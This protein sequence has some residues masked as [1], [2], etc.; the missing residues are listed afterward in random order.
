MNPAGFKQ[1]AED[2]R[3]TYYQKM[4]ES[5]VTRLIIQL[6]I[7]AIISMMI[8]NIYN[9]VDTAFVG[10]LG[11]SASAAV[12]IVFGFMAILQAV[13]FLFG[14]GSGSILGRKLGQK[15]IGD[16][17]VVASTGFFS[18][19]LI[20]IL[21]EV[22]GLFW[23]ETLVIQLGSTATIAPYTR[24]YMIYILLSSPFM[25]ASCAMNT[26]LRYEGKALFAMA[27]MLSGAVLNIFG[28][29]FFMF[30]LHMGIAG[31]GLSTALSQFVGFCIL[32]SPFLTRKTQCRLSFRLISSK[33]IVYMDIITTGLPSMTRQALTSISTILLNMEAG[34][35]GDAAVAAMSIVSRIMF[36]VFA[37]ALGIGQGF[38]PVCGFNYGAGKYRRVRKAYRVTLLSAAVAMVFLTVAVMLQ[39]ENL[40]RLFRDDPE[41]IQV[42]IRALNLQALA[43]LVLPVCMTAEMLYQS[44]GHRAGALLLSVMRN[45]LFMI[46]ALLILS[47]YRGLAGIQEAYPV[48]CMLSFPPSA[49]LAKY[50]FRRLPEDEKEQ[51]W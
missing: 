24:I 45:G 36:F 49:L 51:Q 11:T 43:Q 14:Q 46:P 20:G 6:S 48:A 2:D 34:A 8:S 13:G 47:R 32:L 15:E 4:T 28:D 3:R 40:L 12:G 19:L 30:I 1:Q 33:P 39:P 21:I 18:S 26:I 16:A 44:T 10:R 17:S 37:V 7:P 35:Y 42:G 23:L 9:M 38:Q 50:F 41:V 29:I 5:S 22:G 31:A 25:I 27:G